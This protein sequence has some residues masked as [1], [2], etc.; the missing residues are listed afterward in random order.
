MKKSAAQREERGAKK[1]TA[2]LNFQRVYVEKERKDKRGKNRQKVVE[3][4]KT[5]TKESPN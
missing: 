2:G 5:K 4:K 1:G 3:P